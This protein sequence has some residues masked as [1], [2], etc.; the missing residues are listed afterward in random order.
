[1]IKKN[2]F[3]A[4][5]VSL[6][7]LLGGAGVSLAASGDLF[8]TGPND[9]FRVTSTGA[10]AQ[11]GGITLDDGVT[12]SPA[13]T[14]TDATD[15]TAVLQKTDS[16]FLGITTQAAD[17]VN[18]LTGNLK[19]GN[20]SPGVTQN[21]EDAYIEGTLEVDG[22]VQLDGALDVEGTLTA[23]AAISLGGLETVTTTTA[24]PG[25]GTASVAV[26]ITEIV[27][28][29][30]GTANDEVSLA[31]GVAGQVKVFRLKTDGEAAG[32]AVIPANFGPGT[33]ILFEDAEDSAILYFD[34]TNWQ[35]AHNNGGTIS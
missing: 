26:T 23:D 31:D 35:V 28:D 19:V 16:S 11:K 30:T 29:D 27:S 3:F 21:G 9:E 4:I 2:K 8:S 15:E 33:E 24:D 10:I 22:A 12:D 20:G 25:L 1:M 17:G 7:L 5:A 34:G 13:F 18:I 32:V 14:F 6:F